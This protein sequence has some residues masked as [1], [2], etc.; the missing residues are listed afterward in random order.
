[1]PKDVAAS[2]GNFILNFLRNC[3]ADLQWLYQFVLKLVK[4]DPLSLQSCQVL[5]SIFKNLV[6][7]EWCKIFE[8]SKLFPISLM[9]QGGQ[10]VF[11][12]FH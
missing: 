4:D 6:H 3:H 1:M 11:Q 8:V 10:H 9:A 12:T 5:L 2:W 7:S